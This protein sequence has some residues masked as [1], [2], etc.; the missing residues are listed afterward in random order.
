MIH[1]VFVHGTGVREPE[2]KETF[3]AIEQGL[4]GALHTVTVYPCNWGEQFGSKIGRGR[5]IPLY[6]QAMGL[7]E[8]DP[9]TQSLSRWALLLDDPLIELSLLSAKVDPERGDTLGYTPGSALR[10]ALEAFPEALT[11]SEPTVVSPVEFA[12]LGESAQELLGMDE[13]DAAA[14]AGV[15]LAPS[16]DRELDGVRLLAARAIVAVWMR[17]LMDQGR[18]APTGATR[19]L[20]LGLTFAKL[21]GGIEQSMSVGDDLLS[22]VIKPIT[23]ILSK[24]VVNPALRAATWGSRT[25]RHGLADAATPRAGDILLYQARGARIRDF[26]LRT[27]EAIGEPVVLLAH[28]LGGIACIDM[29]IEQARPCIKGIITAGSQAPYLYEIG[30]LSQLESHEPIP[31]HLPPWLNFFDKNDLLSFL[32]APLMKGEKNLVTDVEVKSNQ[33]F[34]LSHSAYW[35]NSAVWVASAEFIRKL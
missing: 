26:I 23:A 30:A 35:G 31:N 9:E 6:D 11:G 32:A 10:H 29:L 27:A 21:G 24:V 17:L 34:P 33:P 5:S 8:E 3:D 13:L 18:P 4:Q 12:V 19:D 15:Q 7:E 20:V 22:L 1:V 16:G 14:E 2:F 25:Y 28:S